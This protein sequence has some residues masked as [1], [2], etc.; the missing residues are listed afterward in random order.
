VKGDILK[1]GG[2]VE[3]LIET[4]LNGQS[5]AVILNNVLF[6]PFHPVK[7]TEKW[8]FPCDIA[9]IVKIEI[10]SWFNLVVKGNKIVVLNGICAITLGH[11]HRD[12]ILEHPYFGTDKVVK[13]LKRY[14]EYD[15][16]RLRIESPLQCQ[17]DE[18]GMIIELF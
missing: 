9:S 17:R 15:T 16:G 6:T 11:G 12:D 2:I 7:L 13:A 14:E 4:I 1:D 8:I 18:N 5:E 3:C 10:D